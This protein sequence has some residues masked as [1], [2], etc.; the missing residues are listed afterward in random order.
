MTISKQSQ[1]FYNQLIFLY[2][3]VLCFIEKKHVILWLIKFKTLTKNFFFILNLILLYKL[4]LL[5]KGPELIYL[6]PIFFKSEN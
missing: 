2:L 1:N 3:F 4:C 6:N 5:K